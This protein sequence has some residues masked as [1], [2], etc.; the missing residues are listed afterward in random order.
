MQQTACAY[1]RSDLNDDNLR[2]EAIK[3]GIN[4]AAA[5][6]FLFKP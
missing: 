1:P 2:Q 3:P 4:T 6:K 5:I